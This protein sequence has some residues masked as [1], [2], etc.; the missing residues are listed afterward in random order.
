MNYLKCALDETMSGERMTLRVIEKINSR[1]KFL[2]QK[3]QF[4]DVSLRRLLCNALIRPHFDCTCTACC[5]NLKK[6]LKDKLQDTQNKW[7]GFCLKLQCSEHISNGH[8]EK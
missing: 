7:I 2:Y 1:L 5:P 6:K 8:F 3:Y 4:L